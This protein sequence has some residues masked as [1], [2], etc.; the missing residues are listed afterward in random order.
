[1]GMCLAWRDGVHVLP[2]PGFEFRHN[3]AFLSG[4]QGI[5]GIVMGMTTLRTIYT[6]VRAGHRQNPTILSIPDF[7]RLNIKVCG[8]LRGWMFGLG[9]VIITGYALLITE[10]ALTLGVGQYT[11]CV[12]Y[13]I[14]PSTCFHPI[15]NWSLSQWVF[16]LGF[17]VIL[18][19]II[20]LSS[21][22]IGIGAG[23]VFQRPLIALT[24]GI[25]I[26]A[27][28]VLINLITPDFYTP[29]QFDGLLIPRWNHDTAS[30][31]ADTGMSALL[32]IAEP[33]WH[34]QTQYGLTQIGFALLAFTL[35][36]YMLLGYI[37]LSLIAVR[38][39]YRRTR[40]LTA[41]FVSDVHP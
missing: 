21:I 23:I 6:G 13:E 17:A 11:T 14:A 10:Y 33:G 15:Q 20:P 30:I 9:A 19:V 24:A 3:P 12:F 16:G 1:M 38:V 32:G 7:L 34:S 5:I 2:I 29:D 37:V 25:G 36:I 39:K 18:S 22:G 40:T 35:V 27:L 41:Q 31:F 26:R 8:Q 4:L 28:P